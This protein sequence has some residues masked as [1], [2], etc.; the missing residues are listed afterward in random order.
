MKPAETIRNMIGTGEENAVQCKVLENVTGLTGREVKSHIETLRRSGIVICSS[1]CG[2]FYPARLY[3]LHGFIQ[4]EV[5]R[6][7]SIMR[8]LESAEALFDKWNEL[9]NR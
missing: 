2:Y 7:K 3:E 4:R 9:Q 8:T 1:N 6:A 5:H